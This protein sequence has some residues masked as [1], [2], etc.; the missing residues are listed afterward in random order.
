M[1]AD[2]RY[3]DIF[4]IN[5]Y[6]SPFLWHAWTGLYSDRRKAPSRWSMVC[7]KPFVRL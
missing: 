6:N 1:E 3:V 7:G 5:A 2:G 4:K